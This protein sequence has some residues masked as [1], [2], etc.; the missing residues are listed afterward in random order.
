MKKTS[1]TGI[2]ILVAGCFATAVSM[3]VRATM[4]VYLDPISDGLSITTTSFGLAVALQN[5]IWGLGQPIAGAVADRFGTGRVMIVGGVLYIAGLTTTG[6]A[7]GTGT[8]TFGLGVLVGLGLAGL[9]FSVILAA[10]GR[11]VADEKRPMALATAT[12]FGSVGQFVLVPLS[13]ALIDVVGWRQ[14][15][16]LGVVLLIAAMAAARPLRTLDRATTNT[17]APQPL[18]DAL[19][20]AFGHRSYV[21]LLL[22]FFVCGFHVTFVAVHLPKYLEDVGQTARVAA[23]ALATIGL[24]NIAGTI[25]I[26]WLGS[27]VNNA[28]LLSV[29]YTVRTVTFGAFVVLPMSPGVALGSAAVMG[30]VWLSTVPLTSAIVLKQFGPTHAGSLFGFVFLSHQIG[31]FVGT[32]GAALVRDAYGSYEAFWWLSALLGLVAAVIHLFIDESPHDTATPKSKNGPGSLLRRRPAVTGSLATTALILALAAWTYL[33]IP[34]HPNVALEQA[35]LICALH[36]PG[37]PLG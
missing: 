22:G 16:I 27:R 9:S 13:Q 2:T 1:P 32:Y 11:S 10:I 21:L 33:R 14:S 5:L 4:G 25:G 15:L 30:L 37:G 18:S 8:L 12:A 35:A 31:A 28:K 36:L 6:Q 29:L 17:V 19:R 26:G 34:E 7:A 3:G 24:F 20:T 23:L